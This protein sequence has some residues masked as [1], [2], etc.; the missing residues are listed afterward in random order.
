MLRI[1][2]HKASLRWLVIGYGLLVFFWLGPEDDH[3]WPVTLIGLAGG[4]LGVTAWLNGRA[5]SLRWLPLT[6]VL[7][8]ALAG[9]GTSV[10]TVLLMLFKNARHA[11]LY[12]DFSAPLMGE[13]LVRAPV[14]GMAGALVGFGAALFWLARHDN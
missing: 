9:G 1:P 13:V 5:L 10:L 8:G 7:L 3:I 12:P 4:L 14:W 11:H 2:D 6:G